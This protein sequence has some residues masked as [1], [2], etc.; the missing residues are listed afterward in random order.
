[1][2]IA[3]I[4]FKINPVD[5]ISLTFILFEPKIIAFGGVATGNIKAMEALRVAG[6]ISNSGCIPVLTERPAKIGRTI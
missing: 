5:A 6:N 4:R 2:I 3:P 1:M